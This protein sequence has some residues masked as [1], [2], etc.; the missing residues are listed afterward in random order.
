MKQVKTISGLIARWLPGIKKQ[1][2]IDGVYAFA[3]IPTYEGK[4]KLLITWI[5]GNGYFRQKKFTGTEKQC[6]A[7]YYKKQKELAPLCRQSS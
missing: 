3:I 7:Q 5:L 6:V 2:Y 4:I 1:E